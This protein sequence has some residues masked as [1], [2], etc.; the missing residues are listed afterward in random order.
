MSE[1]TRDDGSIDYRGALDSSFFSLHGPDD[2]EE[3]Q[4]VAASPVMGPW[5]AYNTRRAPYH[6]SPYP[7]PDEPTS[8]HAL[9]HVD[10]AARDLDGFKDS[11]PQVEAFGRYPNTDGIAYSRL[12]SPTNSPLPGHFTTVTATAVVTSDTSA[13]GM[14]DDH[15]V[16]SC[17]QCDQTFTGAYR[18]GNCARHVRLKHIRAD[19]YECD[20]SNCFK[21]YQR[22]D[23]RLK[24]MRSRHPELHVPPMQRRRPEASST[25]TLGRVRASSSPNQSWQ[26][27]NQEQI[28]TSASDDCLQVCSAYT[29]TRSSTASYERSFSQHPDS[30]FTDSYDSSFL[31]P[32]SPYPRRPISLPTNVFEDRSL[33]PLPSP[34]R[35]SSQY[36]SDTCIDPALLNS[37]GMNS[38][39]DA[40]YGEHT[41]ENFSGH[42][43][44]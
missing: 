1:Y 43:P 22:Q 12:S 15:E 16:L 33:S 39:A 24:H 27:A 20:A 36:Y 17:T 31:N 19:L 6:S 14:N 30:T 32:Y 8:L 5:S 26:P 7:L 3:F 11:F 37:T 25:Q 44:Y 13:A 29:G 38:E 21:V 34:G 28:D 23:A 18:S 10:Q 4:N 40:I 35:A 9:G 41:P 42:A 2:Y